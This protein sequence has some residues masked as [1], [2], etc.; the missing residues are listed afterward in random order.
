MAEAFGLGLD[1]G[2]TSVK[3]C[4]MAG[5][6]ERWSEVRAHDGDVVGTARAILARRAIPDGTPAVVTGGEGRRQFLLEPAI[7]P[8]AL[9]RAL[10]ALGLDVTAVVS[11]G[12]EDLVVYRLEAGRIV[13]TYAGNKCASGTGEFFAQQ[14]RRMDLPLE[15]VDSPEMDTACVHRL[16]SRCSVFMKSD[17]THKLNKGEADRHDIVK[18]LTHV[19]AGKVLEFLAKARVETGTVVMVGGSARNPHLVQAVREGLPNAQL[20]V[21]VQA[22]YLEAFGAALLAQERGTPL[23]WSVTA[24]WPT[25]GP[26]RSARRRRWSPFTRRGAA[27]RAP[28]PA[29]CS[30]STVAPPPPRWCWSTPPAAR[31]SP[32]TTA[33]PWATR[34]RRCASASPR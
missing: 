20:V 11:V 33:A 9:E 16:S 15:V 3:A 30:A 18:S 13:G 19:M 26:A 2:S 7:A 10:V 23:R 28:V 12:G 29:T 21:P 25:P 14:L 8:E 31:W 5:G 34:C 6:A 17:C 22:P 27:R 1:V 24:R 4:L 32:A